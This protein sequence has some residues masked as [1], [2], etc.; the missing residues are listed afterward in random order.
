MLILQADGVRREEQV[1]TYERRDEGPERE[2]MGMGGGNTPELIPVKDKKRQ[3][4][5]IIC[6]CPFRN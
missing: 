1:E 6:N 3:D 2:Q 5:N 4:I